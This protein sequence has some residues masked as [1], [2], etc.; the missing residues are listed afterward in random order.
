[1]LLEYGGMAFS[2]RLKWRSGKLAGGMHDEWMV[3]DMSR[4]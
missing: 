3:L 1:M 2:G 4:A